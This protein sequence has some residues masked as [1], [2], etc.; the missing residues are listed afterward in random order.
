M[1]HETIISCDVALTKVSSS[2]SR[3]II[4]HAAF[5]TNFKRFVSL[6]N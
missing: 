4:I 3:N 2:Y 5:R 1:K 6:R